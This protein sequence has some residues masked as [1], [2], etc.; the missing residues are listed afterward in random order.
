MEQN[1][2]EIRKHYTLEFKQQVIDVFNSGIYKTK[3]RTSLS[4][5]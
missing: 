3:L 1:N 4:K 5:A 2:I